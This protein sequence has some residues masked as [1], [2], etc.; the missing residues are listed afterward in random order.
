[1]DSGYIVAEKLEDGK[2]GR[3]VGTD[4]GG[5]SLFEDPNRATAVRDSL[6]SEMPTLAVF[7]LNIIMV[8]EVL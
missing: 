7:R 8:G 3:P 5:V 4:D 6:R 1:M 2:V